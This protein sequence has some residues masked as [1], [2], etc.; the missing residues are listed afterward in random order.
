MEYPVYSI[1]YE[2]AGWRTASSATQMSTFHALYRKYDELICFGVEQAGP[3]RE[4]DS[5]V[6]A[7]FL[8]AIETQMM[9]VFPAI[10]VSLRAEFLNLTCLVTCPRTSLCSQWLGRVGQIVLFTFFPVSRVN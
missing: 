6:V 8:S 4:L 9:R 5:Q 7:P 3:V 10:T 2:R 1:P